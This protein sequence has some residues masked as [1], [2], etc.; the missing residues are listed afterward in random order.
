VTLAH[1]FLQ[2]VYGQGLAQ[3]IALNRIAVVTLQK[4]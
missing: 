2:L 1:E 3:V 4:R